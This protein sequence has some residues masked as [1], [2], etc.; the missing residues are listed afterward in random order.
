MGSRVCGASQ[1]RDALS[2]SR[3]WC[4]G[5]FCGRGG[6][7]RSQEFR[8]EYPR[9]APALTVEDFNAEMRQADLFSGDERAQKW[10]ARLEAHAPPRAASRKR[11]AAAV[12]LQD[13]ESHA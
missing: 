9:S 11:S 10:R 4:R 2:A 8:R 5:L 3:C 1:E 6:F 7:Q 13:K 12:D